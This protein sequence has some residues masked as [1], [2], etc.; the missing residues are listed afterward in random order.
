MER[1]NKI[2]S[3]NR[4]YNLKLRR[5]R[6]H[7]LKQKSYRLNNLKLRNSNEIIIKVSPNVTEVPLL[8]FEL[9]TIELI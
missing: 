1:I 5:R 7:S 9:K 2:R 4:L 3:D 8:R 6:S